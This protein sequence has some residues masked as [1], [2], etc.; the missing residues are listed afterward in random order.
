MSDSNKFELTPR[1]GKDERFLSVQ[2]L[3]ARYHV[4]RRTIFAWENDPRS[5]FPR[6]IRL[7]ADPAKAKKFYALSELEA[8]ERRCASKRVAG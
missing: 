6:P 4:G 2:E 1:S 8:F 5:D 3:M 7:G